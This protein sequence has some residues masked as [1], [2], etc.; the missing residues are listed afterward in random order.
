MIATD[1]LELLANSRLDGDVTTSII[2]MEE[3][4]QE[5]VRGDPAADGPTE[6]EQL[7]LESYRTE[8]WDGV[9]IQACGGDARED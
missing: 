2:A 6:I 8:V 9:S 7:D 1:R 5:R 4:A 3:G